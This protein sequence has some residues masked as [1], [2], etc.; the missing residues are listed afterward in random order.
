MTK[1]DK[2]DIDNIK[3]VAICDTLSFRLNAASEIAPKAKKYNDHRNLLLNKDLDAVIISTPLNTHASIATD[4]IAAGVNIY[5]EKT[6]VKGD[7]ETLELYKTLKSNFLDFKLN[8]YKLFLISLGFG[9][10]YFISG[11]F[12]SIFFLI[13]SAEGNPNLP[14]PMNPIL[15]P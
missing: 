7:N 10:L 3:V 6:M 14:R 11:S 15:V 5:C 2:T 9:L 13:A 8:L 12:G 1:I 4:A